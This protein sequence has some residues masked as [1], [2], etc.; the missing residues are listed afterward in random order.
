VWRA[1]QAIF[2]LQ[3]AGL[4]VLSW[5]LWHRFDLTSDFATF[6]QAWSQI[7]SGNLN[8]HLT[9]FP[10]NYPNYGY[11]FWQSHFELLMWPLALLWWVGQSGFTLLVVQDLALSAACLVAL[12]WGLELIEEYWPARGA[13][14]A[15][16]PALLVILVVNPWT[17]WTAAFDFHFQP[18]AVLAVLLAGRDFWAGRRRGWWWLAAVLACGD[19]A[20]TYAVALGL[21][22]LLSGRAR[23]RTG[24]VVVVVALAW[25]ALIALLGS[26]KG[27]TVPYSYG[28]LARHPVG[29][30]IGATLAIVWGV[31]THPSL[32]AHTVWSRR[33]ELARF[34]AAT[35]YLGTLSTVGIAMAVVVFGAN[36]LNASANFV[37]TDAAFQNLAPVMFSAVG[38]VAVCTWLVRRPAGRPIV[39]VACVL[40]VAQALYLSV[41][42]TPRVRT[43]FQVPPAAASALAEVKRRIPATAQVVVSQ[44]VI[45]RFGGRRF[46]YPFLDSFPDGQTV[47]VRVRD[48]VF[49][50]TDWG[51]ESATSTQTA[52]AVSYV[53]NVLRGEV[54]LDADGVT[55][56][57]WSAP[58][59][60]SSVTLPKG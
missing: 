35:G 50:F 23:A 12:R 55:A 11:P 5:H 47:P 3:F 54:V 8:P 7:A 46:A 59:G 22:L 41:V 53:R 43:F 34:L 28:Y 45:G 29:T 38:L 44:G 37:G 56:L 51:I 33:H 21:S 10:Y 40:V 52:A 30:G 32:P 26:G 24:L 19:V 1:G 25:L 31:V 57:R 36:A 17:Y 14:V 49:V 20:A 48:V 4:L 27:S 42:W 13:P 58:P 15:V 18:I 2:A 16:A 39:V 6:Y 60:R 9:I